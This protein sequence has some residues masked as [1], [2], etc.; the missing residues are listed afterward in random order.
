MDNYME[1]L[2]YLIE[3]KKTKKEPNRI[4]RDQ[5]IEAWQKLVADEGYSEAADTY[6][7]NGFTYCGAS[8]VKN[9][10]KHSDNPVE[11]LRTVFSGKMYGKNCA[12]TVPILFHLMTLLLNEKN[13]ELLLISEIIKRIPNALKNKEG[14][15]Y[16]QADRAL[17][18]YIL[19]D[20]H[21]DVLPSLS[22]FVKSGLKVAFIND[23]VL[24]L[25]EV[26]SGMKSDGFSKKCLKNIRL[27][28]EW[29]HPVESE[30]VPEAETV[31]IK[32]ETNVEIQETVTG[33]DSSK[34][35]KEGGPVGVDIS[36]ELEIGKKKL[37]KV[38]K[39]LDESRCEIDK[40][41]ILVS[42][43]N[44]QLAEANVEKSKISDLANA[45][46]DRIT[47][48]SGELSS[49]KRNIEQL[50][51]QIEQLKQQLEQLNKELQERM[52]MTEALSR[53]RAKQSDEAFN[54]LASKLRVEYRDFMDAIDVP[55]D[56]YLGENMREQLKNV[57]SILIKAGIA[58]S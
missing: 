21:V 49:A 57:F 20:L 55:M 1:V 42:T 53:D 18:K 29:L 41:K 52:R 50:K 56:S 22:E 48:L 6:L 34:E 5:F 4:E 16:G 32:A 35:T 26:M 40:Q 44:Q 54:R 24:A 9:Y 19:D 14:K 31:S 10:I 23:F 12:N 38:M 58:I 46:G 13:A 51:Q 15:I 8:V 25:D 39:Q 37:D 36:S 43:L 3:L 7:Y 2:D 27:I 33:L 45:R 17:K 47:A 30:V 11:T 28:Q